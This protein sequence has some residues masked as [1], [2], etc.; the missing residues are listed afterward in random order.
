VLRADANGVP[1]LRELNNDPEI[2]SVLIT[3]GPKQNI[4]FAPISINN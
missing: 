4:W 1:M 2:D 3:S